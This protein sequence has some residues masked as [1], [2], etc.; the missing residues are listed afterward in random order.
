[1][2]ASY[3][4]GERYLRGREVLASMNNDPDGLA[5]W[6]DV[7]PDVG[8][9]LDR[10]LG[11]H[12]FGDIWAGDGLDKRTRRIIVI[13]TLANQNRM[14]QLHGHVKSALQQGFT[15][16][17]ILEIF[18]QLIAY[19]GFPTALSSVEVARNAFAEFDAETAAAET[20]AAEAAVQ[21]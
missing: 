12:C 7:D 11:E 18:R 20:A 2:T 14:V 8:P 16:R 4:T 17:E 3:E 13:T 1:M 10:L 19:A 5:F 15:K 9:E 6:R 21:P